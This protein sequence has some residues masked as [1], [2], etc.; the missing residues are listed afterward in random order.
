M[1]D[2]SARYLSEDI[3]YGLI[4]L[5]GIA[6]LAEAATPAIDEVICWSQERLGRSYLVDGKLSGEDLKETRLPRM[7][8]IQNL[9]QLANI[10]WKPT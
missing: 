1:V 6:A 10:T 8:G 9:E 4:V 2:F 5:R 3:P 7:F